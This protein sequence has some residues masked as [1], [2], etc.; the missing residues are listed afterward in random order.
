MRNSTQLA[1]LE[2]GQYLYLYQHQSSRQKYGSPN[3]ERKF[4][5]VMVP[6]NGRFRL[7]VP[8]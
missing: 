5:I 1:V 4:Q 2:Q 3:Q 6:V 8:A 7:L